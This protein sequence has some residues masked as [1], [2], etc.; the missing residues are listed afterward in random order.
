MREFLFPVHWCKAAFL[1]TN[2]LC[3]RSCVGM[4]PERGPGDKFLFWLLIVNLRVRMCEVLVT[5]FK[6]VGLCY[7]QFGIFFT[8]GWSLLLTEIWFGP[9]YLRL[10]FGLVF[11][12]YGGRSVWFF[13]CFGSPCPEFGFWSFC[14]RFHHRK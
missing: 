12:A 10:K 4:P 5:N 14:L 11:F 13:F 2:S 6:R 1:I 3:T 8:Y 9:F 7:L